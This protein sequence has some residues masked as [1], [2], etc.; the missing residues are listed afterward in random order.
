MTGQTHIRNILNLVSRVL[1][2][3]NSYNKTKGHKFL[4]VIQ[5]DGFGTE[6]EH[7]FVLGRITKA[8][9]DSRN[10]QAS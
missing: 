9:V 5:A 1:L 3:E 6:N 8:E 7:P 2:D 10:G 4:Y